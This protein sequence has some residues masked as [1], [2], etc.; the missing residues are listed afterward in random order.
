MKNVIYVAYISRLH[1]YLFFYFLNN[2]AKST[3]TVIKNCL[4]SNNLCTSTNLL[5]KYSKSTLGKIYDLTS[6]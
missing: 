2:A 5:Y 4:N 3:S 1:I 6:S